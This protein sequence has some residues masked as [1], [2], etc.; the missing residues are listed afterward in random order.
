M[1]LEV[2]IILDGRGRKINFETNHNDRVNQI[3]DW[4]LSTN[5]YNKDG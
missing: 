4:S 2:G 1:V 3:I 5:E